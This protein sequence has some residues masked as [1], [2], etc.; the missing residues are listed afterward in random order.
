[1]HCTGTVPLS[2][3]K[4]NVRLFQTEESKT[5]MH[6]AAGEKYTAAEWEEADSEYE[7]FAA[8]VGGECG[9]D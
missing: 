2:R 1:M 4:Y 7:T 9:G 6:T 5:A 3:Q 8:Y